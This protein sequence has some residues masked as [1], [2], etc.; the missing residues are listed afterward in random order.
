VRYSSAYQRHT[1][2]IV[3]AMAKRCAISGSD[4]WQIDN[5]FG[6]P[7]RP[8]LLPKLRQRF[9]PVVEGQIR[10]LDALNEAWS[11]AFWSQTYRDW[12]EIEPPNLMVA[13]PNPSH[14]L[15]YYRFSSDSW[16]A[17]QQL[18]IDILRKAMSAASAG[19]SHPEQFICTNFMGD[20]PDLD[21]HALAR[22]L[23]L[24]TWDSTRQVMRMSSSKG[25]TRQARCAQTIH[26]AMMSATL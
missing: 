9:S 1:E 10:S 2:R 3:T 17:Y 20:F 14:V 21:H 16:L 5:E 4:R 22:P 8:L 11:T 19:G 23:D 26:I 24:V 25:C 7:I 6:C 18:Q 13:G 12:E 15:D